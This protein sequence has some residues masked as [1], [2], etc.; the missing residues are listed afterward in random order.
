MLRVSTVCRYPVKSMLGE[1]LGAA[2]IDERGLEH[3]RSHAVVDQ[4]TGTVA[5]AKQP[6]LWRALL[7]AS[8]RRE[9]AEVVLAL[10][11]RPEVA[12]GAAE[13]HEWLSELVGRPVRLTGTPPPEAGVERA[14]PEEVLAHGVEAEVGA[15][16]LVLGEAVPGPTFLDYAPLHLLT[17]ATAERIGTEALRYRPNLVVE[18]PAGHPPFAESGWV[19][20]RLV[21]GDVVLRVVLPTPRCPIP[22]LAHGA[23][24]RDPEALRVLLAHNKVEV[25]GFGLLPVAG[26]YATVERGGT[27][28]RGA[29]VALEPDA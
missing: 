20:S 29:A 16:R 6:R 10:P 19:G 12:A 27:V 25:E 7:T 13:V 8:A 11:G 4:A 23:L 21:V 1:D 28:E 22:T 3:D 26:V 5:S 18:T 2:R 17:T 15:P 9:G 14:D 24:P